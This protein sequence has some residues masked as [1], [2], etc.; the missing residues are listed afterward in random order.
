M[1]A[2]RFDK[3]PTGQ[4]RGLTRTAHATLQTQTQPRLRCSDEFVA[5]PSVTNRKRA[6]SSGRF[7]PDTSPNPRASRTHDR[8]PSAAVSLLPSSAESRAGYS[9]DE[10][11][12]ETLQDARG[13][14]NYPESDPIAKTLQ[15]A[16]PTDQWA[17]PPKDCLQRRSHRIYESFRSSSAP[18]GS[19]H[20]F[21][22]HIEPFCRF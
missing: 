14:A 21:A 8:R 12:V 11:I 6:L 22:F 1:L 20:V 19:F 2:S 16:R 9:P 18:H 10:G 15:Y 17:L 3:A 7:S 13:H 4:S 5:N